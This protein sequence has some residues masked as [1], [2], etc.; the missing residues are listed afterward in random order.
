MS[1]SE[2]PEDAEAEES[3]AVAAKATWAAG[4]VPAEPGSRNPLPTGI[5]IWAPAKAIGA[6]ARS[7]RLDIRALR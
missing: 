4:P 7:R 3:K 1:G 6:A 5:V 2:L